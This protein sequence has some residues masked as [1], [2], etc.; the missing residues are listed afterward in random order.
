[1]DKQLELVNKWIQE[2]QQLRANSNEGFVNFAYMKAVEAKAQ[3]EDFTMRMK[4][5]DNL[6]NINS[7]KEE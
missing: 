7:Q 4:E 1:M 2:A 3:I 5:V 6:V